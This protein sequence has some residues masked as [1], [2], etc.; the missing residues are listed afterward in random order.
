LCHRP[1]ELPLINHKKAISVMT[2]KNDTQAREL[3]IDP[4]RSVL[5]QAPA[6][7]GKTTLLVQR[8]LRLL[9]TVKAPEE[10]LAVTF[11]KKAAASMRERVLRFLRMEE[12]PAE[13]HEMSAFEDA[14]AVRDKVEAWGLTENPARLKILTI[15]AFCARLVRQ[16]PVIGG[17]GKM[18]SL[19][20]YPFAAYQE[21]ARRTLTALEFN[22]ALG[23]DLGAL[24]SWRDNDMSSIQGLLTALLPKREK[25]LRVL[26]PTGTPDRATLESVLYELVG[27]EMAIGSDL[28]TSQ[29]SSLGVSGQSLAA[30]ADFAA[31]N[32]AAEKPVHACLG[33]TSLPPA[34]PEYL[35]QWRGICSIILKADGKLRTR[36]DTRDGFPAKTDETKAMKDLLESIKLA[37]PEELGERLA[38]LRDLPDPQY[39]DDAWSALA[40]VVGVLQHC[41]LELEVVFAETGQV[42]FSGVAAAALRGLGTSD[43]PTD[44]AL[45]MD[46]AIQHVLMDECQDSNW[47]QF[48]LLE[49][50]TSGWV[51]GDGRTMFLV[52]D[53]MQSI[54][55][56][57]MADV[58]L[59]VRA[60][61]QGVGGI[62]L[63]FAQLSRNYRS[64]SEIVDWVND[65]VGPAFPDRDDQTFGKIRYAQSVPARPAGGEVILELGVDRNRADE[66]EAL[67]DH[68][69][70][71]LASEPSDYDIAV[72]VRSRSHLDHLLPVMRRR[73]ID[74]S[75]LQ[76]D[77]LMDRP[78]IQDIHALTRALWHPADRVAWLAILRAPWCGLTLSD[79]VALVGS[80]SK[81]SIS[82]LLT[83]ESALAR[84]DADARA[85]VE[86]VAEVMANAR[87]RTGRWPV[88][89]VVEG[90]WVALGGPNLYA[91][92]ATLRDAYRYL[93]VVDNFDDSGRLIDWGS[94]QN[95]LDEQRSEGSKEKTRVSVMTIHESKGLEFDM[96]ILPGLDRPPKSPDNQLIEWLPL[97]SDDQESLLLAPMRS[98]SA[99]GAD[100]MVR[101][102]RRFELEM[103]AAER[104]RLLY[105]AATR[106]KHRLVV[107]ASA[108]GRDDGPGCFPTSMLADLWPTMEGAFDVSKANNGTAANGR[109]EPVISQSLTRVPDGW[110]PPMLEPVNWVPTFFAR[111]PDTRIQYDWAGNRARQVGRVMHRLLEIIGNEGLDKLS[112]ARLDDI[113]NRI[114]MLLKRAGLGASADVKDAT[115]RLTRALDNVLADQRGRW[116]LSSQTEGA[117]ELP[118]SGFVNGAL[119]NAVV[120]RTFVAD[121]ERWIVDW[122]GGYHAGGGLK[123][124]L[125]AEADRHRAQLRL[126]G[127]LFSALDDRPLRLGLYL[128]MHSAWVEVDLKNKELS[129]AA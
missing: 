21:A 114:P 18:P 54:Y 74:F 85:R 29:L 103:T 58:A 65:H 55:R 69:E 46:H 68:I 10:I 116:L 89:D 80:R 52:G 7:S 47:S 121:G 105:V 113:R 30:L 92:A 61:D 15:D 126:Y 19:S 71:A 120:D 57:R 37:A 117:C 22:D 40:S 11:T 88:R 42:D 3:A 59:F 12:P 106:A 20:Q 124:F 96:V 129:D 107:S 50:L 63:E 118:L 94:L 78:A 119:V 95:A 5:V 39:H 60:R 53:P 49:R 38:A 48:L 64:Q 13:A 111:D 86:H 2:Q 125:A 77:L 76:L 67:A 93:A 70:R 101:L 81:G 100:G 24:L 79:L 28:L 83:D 72:L 97:N 84:L 128:P 8:Y 9:K 33:M 87:A 108:V 16:M 25:W 32:S 35:P 99:S 123:A 102:I 14:M 91:D 23:A 51:G 34:S 104:K 82:A 26:G 6:G 41:A 110:R 115:V 98:S 27:D 4:R 17:L 66:G 43:S 1:V 112:D 122:K 44:L 127:R 56:F 75:S 36:V 90:C 62:K 109:T 45:Y 31:R 73:G